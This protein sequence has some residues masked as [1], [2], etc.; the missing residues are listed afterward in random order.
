MAT[1]AEVERELAELKLRTR[2]LILNAVDNGE[3]CRTGGY[4]ALRELGLD[5][6]KSFGECTLYFHISV[7]NVPGITNE[8]G[9]EWDENVIDQIVESIQ[10]AVTNAKMPEEVI[11]RYFSHDDTDISED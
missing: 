10:N 11:V 7:E 5:V 3:V 9:W 8:Y 4:N 2:E 6:P 1:K